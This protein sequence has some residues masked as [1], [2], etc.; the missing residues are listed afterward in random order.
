M[1]N[2]KKNRICS[3]RRAYIYERKK[4][5]VIIKKFLSRAEN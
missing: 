3:A 1:C 2:K 4:N 5:R